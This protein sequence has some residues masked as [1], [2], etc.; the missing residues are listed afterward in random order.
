MMFG[1]TNQH[2]FDAREWSVKHEIMR[3]VLEELFNLPEQRQA[4]RWDYFYEHPALRLLLQLLEAGAAQLLATGVI[5]NLLTLRPE[6]GTLL[7]IHDPAWYSR[8]TA[9]D[10]D[11]PFATADETEA[12][13]VVTAPISS[14]EEFLAH[15]PPELHLQ[16]P[17]QATATMWLGI[18]LARR[19]IAQRRYTTDAAMR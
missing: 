10:S 13:S 18:D 11:M 7:L 3:E 14:D 15:F 1:P 16:M 6:I 2:V 19:E 5:V 4:D 9:A 12:A 17:A 8:I